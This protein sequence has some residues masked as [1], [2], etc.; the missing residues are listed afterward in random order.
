MIKVKI[1]RQDKNNYITAFE[2]SGHA[3]SGPYGHDLVCAAVTAVS[4]GAVNAVIKLCDI[5]PFIEQSDD[6]G[7]LY[8][9]LPYDLKQDIMVKANLLFEGM[10]ISLQTIE[11]DY[12]SFIDIN[13]K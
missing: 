10:L 13:E 9:S 3:G 4:F 6:G 12:Q 7:Y 5:D 1:Y 2:I 8:V 11:R